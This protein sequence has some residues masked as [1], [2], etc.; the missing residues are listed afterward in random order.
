M[1]TT[2]IRAIKKYQKRIRKIKKK[3]TWH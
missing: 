2:R 1:L 3:A